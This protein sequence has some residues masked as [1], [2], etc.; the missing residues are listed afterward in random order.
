M[1]NAKETTAWN[2][3]VMNADPEVYEVGDE[4]RTAAIAC[5]YMGGANNGGL[6]AFLPNYW[7][8]S[9]HEVLKCL[10]KLARNPRRSSFGKSSKLSAKV[11][12]LPRKT[13]DGTSSNSFGL[14]SLMIGTF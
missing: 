1:G 9:G 14:M 11:S 7:D 13:N 10:K 6:N 2:N 12:R 8:L 4:R 5:L 3:L